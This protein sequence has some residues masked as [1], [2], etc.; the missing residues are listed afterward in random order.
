MNE[1]SMINDLTKGPIF[2]RMI[3][4]MMPMM[5]ANALQ[6]GFNLVDMY[7]VGKYAGTDALSAVSIAGQLTMLMF[8]LFLGVAVCGQIYVA[9]VVGLGRREELNK[10]IGNV[11]F[12]SI[13]VGAFLMLIIPLGIPIL[14][15]M[16]T[17]DEIIQPTYVYLVILSSVNVLVAL[18]NGLSGI[19]R[20]MGDS[21]RP[22]LF[23]MVATVINIGLD[24]LFICVFKWGV[25]GAAWATLIGQ[26]AAAIFSIVYLYI[27]REEFGFD[28]KMSSLKPDAKILNILLKIGVPVAAKQLAIN[29]SMLFVNAQING[30]GVLAVA[31]TGV[32]NKLIQLMTIVSQAMNDATAS[33]VGQNMAA[34]KFDRVRRSVY[35]SVGFCMIFAVVICAL[36]LLFPEQIFGIFSSDPEVIAQA[37]GYLQVSCTL[38]VSFALMSPMLGLINGVGDTVLNMIIAIADGVIGRI[39]LSLIFGYACGMGALGFYLGHCLAGYISVIWGGAYFL[40]GRWEKRTAL[41]K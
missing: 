27:K 2:G 9:Q 24:Y 8:S 12:L 32:S 13:V 18:Y 30:F 11:V 36:F 3:K 25:V 1:K 26:S 39:A 19:L 7:F 23:V 22:M 41:M 34:G 10:V 35:D 38:V 14:R 21:R 6:V 33:F 5:A 28:F 40:R 20:G 4:F 29:L 15:I 17:P 16:N 31:V 37:P